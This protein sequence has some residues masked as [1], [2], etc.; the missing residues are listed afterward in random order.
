MLEQVNQEKSHKKKIE[1][2]D[3]CEVGWLLV[4]QNYIDRTVILGDLLL[5]IEEIIYEYP[6]KFHRSIK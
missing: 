6:T 1:K 3:S 2:V 5:G 4:I